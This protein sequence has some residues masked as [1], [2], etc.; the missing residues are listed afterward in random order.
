VTPFRYAFVPV[1]PS[2]KVNFAVLPRM[3]AYVQLRDCRLFRPR[4]RRAREFHS[5]GD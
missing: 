2:L 5:V 3:Y 4:A 1:E